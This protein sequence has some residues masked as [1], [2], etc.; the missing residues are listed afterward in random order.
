M[1]RCTASHHQPW[2]LLL[3]LIV[4]Q[5]LEA[6]NTAVAAWS[7]LD[8]NAPQWVQLDELTNAAFEAFDCN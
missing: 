3:L 5:C 7:E 2:Y 8:K 4:V 6:A 1:T